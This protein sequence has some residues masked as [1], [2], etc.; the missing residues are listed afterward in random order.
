MSPPIRGASLQAF[1]GQSIAPHLLFMTKIFGPPGSRHELIREAQDAMNMTYTDDQRI[2]LQHLDGPL[3]VVN[4]VAGAGKTVI[5][6]TLLFWFYL[7]L[8]VQRKFPGVRVVYLA[9]TQHLVRRAMQEFKAVVSRVGGDPNAIGGLGFD[10]EINKD[11][12]WK[13]LN[14]SMAALG[15]DEMVIVSKLSEMI[16]TLWAAFQ[17]LSHL[18]GVL[19]APLESSGSLDPVSPDCILSKFFHMFVLPVSSC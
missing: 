11:M 9:T 16:A 8:V 4:C 6:H 19:G 13:H 2:T 10:R 12:W 15:V 17:D 5:L 1:V 7:V 14:D 18:L 3:S